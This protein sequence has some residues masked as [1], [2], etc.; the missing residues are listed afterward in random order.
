MLEIE[1]EM[2]EIETIELEVVEKQVIY[3]YKF[4][5]VTQILTV[6]KTL[7]RDQAITYCRSRDFHRPQ[8]FAVVKYII[9]N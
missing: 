8:A 4:Q 2:S 3:P 6:T 9:S 1:I 7:S 5:P